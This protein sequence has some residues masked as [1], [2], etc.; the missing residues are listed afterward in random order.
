LL[1][2]KGDIG[3]SLEEGVRSRETCKT[4]TYDDDL[5]HLKVV[6]KRKMWESCTG[7][8]PVI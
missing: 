6:V 2:K 1:V 4:T 5:S 7:V 3:P 8:V